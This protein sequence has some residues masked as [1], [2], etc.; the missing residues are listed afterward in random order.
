MNSEE[1]LY[2]LLQKTP[3]ATATRPPLQLSPSRLCPDW[4]LQVP[5]D[6]NST[7]REALDP[8]A[9]SVCDTSR[10]RRGPG[11]R[12]FPGAWDCTACEELRE[13]SNQGKWR[14]PRVTTTPGRGIREPLR[15]A[16]QVAP[17]EPPRAVGR[18]RHAGLRDH[19][20][21]RAR[22]RRRGQ[23]ENEGHSPAS[24]QSI[25][26]QEAIARPLPG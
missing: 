16:W 9:T 14:A 3:P 15:R 4:M 18:G 26:T 1:S 19:T 25:Q 6:S 22:Q 12:E 5:R 23:R 7:L 17:C 8:T 21:S 11:G 10:A 13:L 20:E 2:L 24:A